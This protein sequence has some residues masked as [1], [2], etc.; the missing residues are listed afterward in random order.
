MQ[1]FQEAVE[2][3]LVGGALIVGVATLGPSEPLGMC[4]SS[5]F[6]PRCLCQPSFVF[7]VGPPFLVCLLVHSAG[8]E[9]LP[10]PEG[11]GSLQSREAGSGHL[12]GGSPQR[13]VRLPLAPQQPDCA[14]A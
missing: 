11:G 6:S 3:N 9:A 8:T 7:S 4:S 10:S 2:R 1:V 12:D 13:E 5:G 14:P